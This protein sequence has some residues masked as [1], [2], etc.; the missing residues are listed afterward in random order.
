M[1]GIPGIID[2]LLCLIVN[3]VISCLAAQLL[4]CFDFIFYSIN[5]RIVIISQTVGSESTVHG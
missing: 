1:I 2:F 5:E 3:L 4:Y